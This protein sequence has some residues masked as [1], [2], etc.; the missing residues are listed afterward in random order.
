MIISSSSLFHLTPCYDRLWK[1]LD[2]SRIKWSYCKEKHTYNKKD[3]DIWVAMSCFTDLPLSLAGRHFEVYGHYGIGLTKAWA[4]KKK[5]NPVH[6]VPTK[7]YYASFIE[8]MIS[9][10]QNGKHMNRANALHLE[11]FLCFSKNDIGPFEHRLYSRNDYPFYD[12][13]EWRYVPRDKKGGHLKWKLGN[14][15]EEDKKSDHGFTKFSVCDITRIIVRENEL[16]ALIEKL[17]K[18]YPRERTLLTKIIASE[19]LSDY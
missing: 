3:V 14:Y 16:D 19:N 7:S 17:E 6:Y 8:K 9:V 2:K 10:L 4:Y 13:R 15:I 1:I 5:L 11:S 18:R 12:E